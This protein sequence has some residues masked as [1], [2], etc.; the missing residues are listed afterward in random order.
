MN[1]IRL[2]VVCGVALALGCSGSDGA[3]GADGQ[4]ASVT[5]EPAGE[6]CPKGGVKIQVASGTA[7]H[8]CSG[9]NG[10]NG[11]NG[12]DGRNGTNGTN[13]AN[14]TNGTNGANGINGING[15]DGEG[16]VVTFEAEGENCPKGGLRIQVGD[17]TPAYVCNG[18]NGTNGI[19]GINGTNG[20]DGINGTDGVNG[21]DGTNGTDGVNGTNGTNGINGTNGTNGTNGQ[22]AV[23]TP[24]PKGDNCPAGGVKIQ[25]GDADP[26]YVCNAVPAACSGNHAPTI[27]GITVNPDPVAMGGTAA[28]TIVATDADDDVLTIS[29]AGPGGTFAGGTDGVFTFTPQAG[30]QHLNYSVTVTDGC[31][32]A[33][34]SFTVDTLCQDGLCGGLKDGMFQS[35]TF[36]TTSGGATV[37]TSAPGNGNVG[38]G[39]VPAGVTTAALSQTLTVLPRTL[40]LRANF[41]STSVC[42]PPDAFECMMMPMGPTPVLRTGDQVAFYGYGSGSGSWTTSSSCLGE[43][44]YGSGVVYSLGNAGGSQ[45]NWTTSFDNALLEAVD[46]QTCPAI[47]TVLNGDMQGNFGWTPCGT[48]SGVIGYADDA[49][50]PY[51]KVTK[52]PGYCEILCL[53]NWVSTPLPATMAHPAF[54]FDYRTEGVSSGGYNFIVLN[55]D[56]TIDYRNYDSASWKSVTSCVGAGARGRADQIRISRGGGCGASDHIDLRNVRLEDDA[57]AC[58]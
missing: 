23:A 41:D 15:I 10:T 22:S 6:N 27:T 24:E 8:V 34:A 36:W 51:V 29:I 37:S 44:A 48:G 20:T 9:T 57:V 28:V 46:D 31:E 26:V 49:G 3:A 5:A 55:N 16:V 52:S 35:T 50:V 17:G 43:S 12:V 42:S 14:G 47:G 54:K 33:L 21:T 25:V 45:P 38:I 2:V 19:D 53:S 58:P 56:E 30:D 7:T 1:P 11:V 40:R 13:G 32:V 39:T 18:T 4:G